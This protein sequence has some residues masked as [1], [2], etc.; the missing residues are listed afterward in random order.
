MRPRLAWKPTPR[1]SAICR[2][3][4]EL[5][6]WNSSFEGCHTLGMAAT[7]DAFASAAA[8]FARRWRRRQRARRLLEAMSRLG[9]RRSWIVA[10][11]AWRSTAALV[12]VVVGL[13]V[14]VSFLARDLDADQVS[15]LG[16]G[17]AALLFGAVRLVGGVMVAEGQSWSDD[18][19][20]LLILLFKAD[21]RASL[22][23]DELAELRVLLF[24][25]T[26]V[27]NG[28]RAASLTARA[29]RGELSEDEFG[30]IIATLDSRGVRY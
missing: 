17:I 2:G 13:T 8:E 14:A 18:A 21:E 24:H 15:A 16:V 6:V 3:P 27:V 22:T 20:R 12:V 25:G 11:R 5:H 26:G 4:H 23:A 28:N 1:D 29:K 9:S 19:R 10:R 7:T 30:D